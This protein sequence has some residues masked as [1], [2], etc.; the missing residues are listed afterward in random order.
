MCAFCQLVCVRDNGGV[1]KRQP[2]GK[3]GFASFD[4]FSRLLFDADASGSKW[5]FSPRPRCSNAKRS[6]N[7]VLSGKL[8]LAKI[9]E[10]RTKSQL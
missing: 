5:V 2:M 6:N 10:A 9:S 3:L 8:L 4:R 1:G 7:A